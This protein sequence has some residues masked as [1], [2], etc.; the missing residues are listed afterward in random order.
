M[1]RKPFVNYILELVPPRLVLRRKSKA[2]LQGMADSLDRAEYLADQGVRQRFPELAS[3]SA[4][5]S[6][7]NE[8]GIP[9][10]PSQTSAQY[11]DAVRRAWEI[12][13][14]AGTGAGLNQRL[15]DAGYPNALVATQTRQ[16]YK[17]G[18]QTQRPVG[19]WLI[20]HNPLGS[21][22]R[23]VVVLPPAFPT[24]AITGWGAE[25]RT[26]NVASPA[27]YNPFLGGLTLLGTPTSAA[28]FRFVASSA[29][30]F[31]TRNSTYSSITQYVNGVATASIG[32]YT[33]P[34]SGAGTSPVMDTLFAGVTGYVPCGVAFNLYRAVGGPST[35]DVFD[36]AAFPTLAAD[37]SDEQKRIASI[38]RTWKPA[39]ATCSA[40]LLLPDAA[41][42]TADYYPA[43]L[44]ADTD[45]RAT[46]DT[47][48]NDSS[49][50][51]W[52]P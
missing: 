31:L 34:S 52:S 38:I 28:V 19:E 33:F 9:R 11:A 7:G 36:F 47:N 18:V 21:W 41:Q 6:L 49:H 50:T 29:N 22:S 42:V 1:A 45:P 40:I 10:G 25:L 13:P 46:A 14:T 44:T 15:I 20:D 3:P 24:Q 2:F 48:A 32:P 12:W 37:G 51:L 43:G 8:R 17:N 39:F 26:I 5:A 35:G 27:Q 23:F 16:W 4:L 30:A